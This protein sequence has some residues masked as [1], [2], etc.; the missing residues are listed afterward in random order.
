M[1]NASDQVD[2][3]STTSTAASLRART[4]ACGSEPRVVTRCRTIQGGTISEAVKAR[5]SYRPSQAY[6]LARRRN[7]IQPLNGAGQPR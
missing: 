3:R 6:S 2:Q 5:N 4:I 7:V 1:E